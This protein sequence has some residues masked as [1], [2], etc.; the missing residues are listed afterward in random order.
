M[1]PCFLSCL[2]VACLISLCAGMLIPAAA[3]NTTP[4]ASS[5][6]SN[7]AATNAGLTAVKSQ[8][9]TVRVLPAAL[10]DGR[11]LKIA[12]MPLLIEYPKRRRDLPPYYRESDFQLSPRDVELLH[13]TLS[14][15]FADT[16]F[17]Q[18]KWLLV[19][20]AATADLKLV[21]EFKEFWLAAP[22]KED[23]TVS[24]TF[25]EE[26]ARF[27]ML[28]RIERASDKQH[29]VEFSDKR[30]LRQLGGPRGR[31][32]RFTVV[33]FWRDMRLDLDN[34]ARQLQRSVPGKNSQKPMEQ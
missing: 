15:A 4:P 6:V 14:E 19:T 16:W 28:G 13:K 11:P 22:L 27:T 33:T 12:V 2:R 3:D 23:I 10:D 7:R 5:Q 25:T 21:V 24:R 17:K 9:D 34:I 18:Q 29:I 1:R 30:K 8:L 31:M 26:S 20:D 32:D